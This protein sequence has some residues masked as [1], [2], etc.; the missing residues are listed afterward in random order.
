M[1]VNTGVQ[2]YMQNLQLTVNQ[3]GIG[4]RQTIYTRA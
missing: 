2:L 1:V 3:E 4:K